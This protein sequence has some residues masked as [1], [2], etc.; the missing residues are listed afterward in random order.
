MRPIHLLLLSILCI[1]ACKK[2]KEDH[3]HDW[4]PDG[5]GPA[6]DPQ[7]GDPPQPIGF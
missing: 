1:A 4:G 6:R 2:E 3:S 5:R 7:P